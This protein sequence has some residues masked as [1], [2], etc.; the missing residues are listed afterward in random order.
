MKRGVHRAD[1]VL[2]KIKRGS[3]SPVLVDTARGRFLVKLRGAAQ[4]IPT[5]VSEIVV[6]ELASALSLPVPELALITLD[7]D[8]PSRD[9]NDELADLLRASVGINLGFRWLEG[10]T[11]LRA[12]DVGRIDPELAALVV[13]LDGL[14]QNFDR[15]RQNPNILMWRGG[16]W[17]IDHGAALAFHYDWAT[18]DEQSPRD[19]APDPR[20]H[21]LHGRASPL[22]TIDAEATRI[23]TRDVLAA[24]ADAVPDDFFH[25]AF[26]GEDATRIRAAY[27]AFLWKRLKAPRPFLG[28]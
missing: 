7:V 11:D 17:L 14:V 16:P 18:L 15:T 8:T 27:A 5:L 28:A 20:A 10:A 13:W 1:V 2:E 3:S 22:T 25:A 4:G 9:H 19:P 6:A 12:D 26:P 24:A 23:L 21:L